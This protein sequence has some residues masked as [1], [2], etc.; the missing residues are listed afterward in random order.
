MPL[1]GMHGGVRVIAALALITAVVFGFG[2]LVCWIADMPFM[3]DQEP[4]GNGRL[5]PEDPW[6]WTW[7]D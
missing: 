4:E 6:E 5:T 7:H 3:L 1:D 2:S